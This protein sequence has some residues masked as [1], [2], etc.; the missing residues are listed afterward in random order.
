MPV[1]KYEKE[2]LILIRKDGSIV[3][4]HFPT[5]TAAFNHAS[6]LFQMDSCE[7]EDFKIDRVI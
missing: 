2:K 5:Y 7:F 4:I 6:S 3:E 1:T